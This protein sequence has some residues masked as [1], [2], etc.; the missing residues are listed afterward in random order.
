M[1]R[2]KINKIVKWVLIGGFAVYLVVAMYRKERLKH[3]RA[4]DT[5]HCAR[6]ANVTAKCSSGDGVWARQYRWCES[7]KNLAATDAC[8]N[9]I[10]RMS[11]DDFKDGW[12]LDHD[13]CIKD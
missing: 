3:D 8:L 7:S 1:K 12:M 2:A 6:F 5:S 4:A 11:C 13:V 10:E 9:E